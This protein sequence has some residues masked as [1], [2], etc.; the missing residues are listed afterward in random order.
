MAFTAGGVPLTQAQKDDM[1]AALGGAPQKTTATVVRIDPAASNIYQELVA[2]LDEARLS[3][4]DLALPT[5][6]LYVDIPAN[7]S[8]D[9]TG[10]RILDG[11]LIFRPTTDYIPAFLLGVRSRLYGFRCRIDPVS[12]RAGTITGKLK[13]DA[14]DVRLQYCELLG[15]RTTANMATVTDHCLTDNGSGSTYGF[16]M[17]HC[18]V[19]K[20][21]FTFMQASTST[22]AKSNFHFIRN[23]VRDV[24]SSG[25]GINSPSA[26]LSNA[27]WFKNDVRLDTAIAG[28]THCLGIDVASGDNIT[29]EGN[30]ISGDYIDAIH[31]EENVTNARI[32]DNGGT[33]RRN[34]L[35]FTDNAVANG[36]ARTTIKRAV[37]SGNTFHRSGVSV[38]PVSPAYG[39][40]AVW[41]GSP[42]APLLEGT[43]DGNVFSGFTAGVWAHGSAASG[44]AVARYS[45]N[46]AIDC[47][48]GFAVFEA[49][50]A[51]FRNRSIRCTHGVFLKSSSAE[52]HEFDKCTNLIDTAQSTDATL[53]N[54]TVVTPSQTGAAGVKTFPLG[55]GAGNFAVDRA[56]LSVRAVGN[57]TGTGVFKGAQGGSTVIQPTTTYTY[58]LATALS[59]SG[60]SLT[61]TATTTATSTNIHMVARIEGVWDVA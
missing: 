36:G 12:P 44:E 38:D 33:V 46:T 23:T 22:H 40:Q 24:F 13:S 19:R 26:V 11:N 52:G 29:I 42:M 32:I 17:E 34:A 47:G 50:P 39:L 7:Q 15:R 37:I 61:A 4:L 2:A 43:V 1:L 30:S 20:F 54:W 8:L 41:D 59:A 10:V 28:H 57:G 48:T 14:Y 18:D 21:N 3:G 5:A 16:L 35:F 25:L 55:S 58:G 49:G 6:P 60:G 27:S 51:L 53:V 56:S 31:L 9:F 45:N